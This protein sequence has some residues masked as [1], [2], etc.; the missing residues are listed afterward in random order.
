[1]TANRR[2]FERW[3]F[4]SYDLPTRDTIPVIQR[5]MR[6]SGEGWA[7]EMTLCLA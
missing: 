1:M 5:L 2:V 6:A 3:A 4:S 7:S